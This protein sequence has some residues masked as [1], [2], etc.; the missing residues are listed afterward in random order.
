MKT[1]AVAIFLSFSFAG[2]A[3]IDS[4]VDALRPVKL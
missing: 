4:L 1:L 3:F 2:T